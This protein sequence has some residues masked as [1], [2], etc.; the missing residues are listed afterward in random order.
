GFSGAG[1]STLLRLINLLERPSA[2][3]VHVAGE[4]LT[5]LDAAGLRRA[6]QRIGMIFQQYNLLAN[7]TVA[8]NVAFPLEIVGGRTPQQIEARVAECLRIVGLEGKA[9]QYPAK[10]SGG[11]KQRVGIARAL[12]TEPQV[13]LCDEPTS[14]LDPH[15]TQEILAVLRDI[16]T[17]LGV[18]VV[19]VSHSMSVVRALCSRV[20]VMDAGRIVEELKIREPLIDV[21]R[22]ESARRLLAAAG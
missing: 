20:A 13:L 19:I 14:A 17:R 9:T 7:R 4:E 8:S 1:K 12:A 22:S 21:P 3:R 16:N 15:T 18:T 11:Q 2:G 5:A 10:L 6:R